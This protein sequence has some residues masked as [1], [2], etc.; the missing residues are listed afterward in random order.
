MTEDTA[1]NTEEMSLVSSPRIMVVGCARDVGASTVTLGMIVAFVRQGVALA[2]G[3]MGYS[4]VETTHYRRTS[5]RLSHLLDY[6][7]LNAEEMKGSLARLSTGSEMILIQS[8][9]PL[10][11]KY[12]AGSSHTSPAEVAKSLG[13]SVVVVLDARGYA[14]SF[15]ALA[16]GV[17]EFDPELGQIG[18][19]ANRVKNNEHNEILRQSLA[20]IPG[21]VY[22]GG[23]PEGDA[24]VIGADVLFQR[25]GN[26][27]LLPR[28]GLVLCGEMVE[29]NIDFTALKK[30]AAG[31]PDLSV[32]TSW[33]A[34][35]PRR[36][37]IGV[38]DD[39]A[40]H[41]TVQD[42]LDL[43]RRQGAEIVPFSPIA[44]YRLPRD[45]DALYLPGGYLHLYAADLQNNR[46]IREEIRKFGDR[47]GI[48]YA[49]GGSAAYLCRN[50]VM[51]GGELYEMVGL[52]PAIA[53]SILDVRETVV[54]ESVSIKLH[55]DCI[56]GKEG[57]EVH[58]VR[59]SRWILHTDEDLDYAFS[60]EMVDAS[61]ETQL[62]LVD[63]LMPVS[64]VFAAVMQTHWASC[65]GIA[66]HFLDAVM[67]YQT[68]RK[69]G[70]DSS[71]TQ[72]IVRANDSDT[73]T[74]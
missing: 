50:V 39:A 3:G 27:S 61:E 38:A 5:G 8:D 17:A 59:D 47:G 18:V 33:M 72:P 20:D 73:T 74:S 4:L 48:I 2:V 22:L 30:L 63:G 45:L 36:C 11:D 31:K 24:D 62:S 55:A 14:E 7:A 28:S 37:R 44:D 35:L 29:K 52:V 54:P 9:F 25:R 58:G 67:K 19:I 49:E 1:N 68:E 40:F 21:L 56:L 16:K 10:F 53:H 51:H 69:S 64:N 43:L 70:A 60:V 65:F 66:R 15:A 46:E 71:G 6:H 12:P 26:R 41:L 57:D 13:L 42:N 23:V 34:A 32:P